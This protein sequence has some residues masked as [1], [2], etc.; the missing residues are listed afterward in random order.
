ME[1][2]ELLV[3]FTAKK[4]HL[5]LDLGVIAHRGKAA[6]LVLLVKG[7]DGDAFRH[8]KKIC[9]VAAVWAGD[10][11]GAATYSLPIICLTSWRNNGLLGSISGPARFDGGPLE[12][13][14]GFAFLALALVDLALVREEAGQIKMGPGTLG[15][16]F[17]GGL[18]LLAR[19]PVLL[20]VVMQDAQITPEGGVSR[21]VRGLMASRRSSSSRAMVFWSLK[22]ELSARRRSLI[23]A[24]SDGVIRPP[25]RASLSLSCSFPRGSGA[26]G[27]VTGPARLTGASPRPAAPANGAP[28]GKGL[29]KRCR[30]LHPPSL[31]FSNF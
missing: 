30:A 25:V 7:G 24:T 8:F 9:I 22:V 27:A 3:A 12:L 10:L 14:V 26:T 17:V 4:P 13:L 16:N 23:S 20:L 29:I 31:R 28:P 18:Q 6:I 1:L 11:H 5:S 21:L 2:L 15:V 19:L